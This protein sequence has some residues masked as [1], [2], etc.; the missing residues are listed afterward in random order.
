MKMAL[1]MDNEQYSSFPIKHYWLKQCSRHRSS[2]R[3]SQSDKLFTAKSKAS[4]GI[5]LKAY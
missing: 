4:T 2:D 5:E 1:L 3:V